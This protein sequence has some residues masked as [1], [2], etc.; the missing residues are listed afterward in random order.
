MSLM[1]SFTVAAFTAIL[2]AALGARVGTSGHG[3]DIAHDLSA[4]DT[5]IAFRAIFAA[6]AVM[7]AQ[8]PF[9]IP[10]CCRDLSA[11]VR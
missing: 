7:M 2:L 6:A 10:A 8:S 9:V 11:V 1:S 4:T 3:L 5:V